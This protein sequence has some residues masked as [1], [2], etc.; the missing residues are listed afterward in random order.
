MLCLHEWT[1]STV[2]TLKARRWRG[3]FLFPSKKI[4]YMSLGLYEC[5]IHQSIILYWFVSS[6]HLSATLRSRVTT[7]RSLTFA[8]GV[9]QVEV[10]VEKKEEEEE[11]HHR[12]RGSW[13]RWSPSRS[14]VQTSAF[15][16]RV[17]TFFDQHTCSKCT[18]K[19][20]LYL[21]RS[22]L[23]PHEQF[24]VY[25]PKIFLTGYWSWLKSPGKRSPQTKCLWD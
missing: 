6:Q 15:T 3:F 9:D 7:R 2:R 22:Q 10:E 24:T 18:C 21:Q 25:Q 20:L 16:S 14:Q 1:T 8:G 13:R 17:R 12:E 23:G 11:S 19:N 4:S 5:L